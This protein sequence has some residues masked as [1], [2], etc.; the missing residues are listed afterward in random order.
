MLSK[1]QRFRW[2]LVEARLPKERRQAARAERWKEMAEHV[3][4]R[5]E[6]LADRGVSGVSAIT[7]SGR[8]S[9][10]IDVSPGVPVI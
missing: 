5:D 4:D 3:D 2:W 1:R 10:G 8:I 6:R 7:P 9:T